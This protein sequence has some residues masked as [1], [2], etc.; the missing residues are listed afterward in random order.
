M[1]MNLRDDVQIQKKK[2]WFVFDTEN[3]SGKA[4]VVQGWEMGGSKKCTKHC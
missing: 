1:E 2:R 4:T 3:A